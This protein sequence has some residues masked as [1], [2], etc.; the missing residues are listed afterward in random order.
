MACGRGG[1][2]CGLAHVLGHARDFLL[3]DLQ[4]EGIGGV[5]HVVAELLRERPGAV[6]DGGVAFA[7]RALQFGAAEHEIAQR[8]GQC[9]ALRRCKPRRVGVRGHRLVFGVE[10]GIGAQP[11]GEVDDPGLVLGVRGAQRRRIGDGLQVPDLRPGGTQPLHGRV[12]H[13]GQ[14]VEVGSH[15]RPDRAFER[16]IGL[17][18]EDVER[19]ADMLGAQRREVRPFGA[20][21]QRVHAMAS[22]ACRVL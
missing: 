6:L 14:R 1:R 18:Q 19:R 22:A 15:V 13:G 10:A 9:L 3:R 4:R 7:R 12:E 2:G 17:G 20:V 16:R 11:R 21:Q 8:V 5:E